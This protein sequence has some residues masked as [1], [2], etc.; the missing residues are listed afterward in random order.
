[1]MGNIGEELFD[2][3]LLIRGKLNNG[4]KLESV[5]GTVMCDM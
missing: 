3:A 5:S 1:M 2:V 4:A